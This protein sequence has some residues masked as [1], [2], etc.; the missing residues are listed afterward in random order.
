MTARRLRVWIAAG[1]VGL[2]GGAALAAG[3]PAQGEKVFNKE[4]K[5]CH[6]AVD[7]KK[8]AG[9]HLVGIIGR[10]AASV[11]GYS[12]S[13]AM[14]DSGIVW[15]EAA[16]DKFLAD[17]KAVVAHTKMTFIGLKTEQDRE[18]VIAYLKS[19]EK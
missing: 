4:C 17:P 7:E 12:Y 5:L 14:K 13:Q 2:G 1:L 15:D 18:D 16:L 8:R 3:D 9:P 11:E 10:P 6:S 19:L